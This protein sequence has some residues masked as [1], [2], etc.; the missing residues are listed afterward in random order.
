MT[1]DFVNPL[2]HEGDLTVERQLPG[3]I[4]VSAGWL[5]SRGLRLPV[6]I[7]TNLGPAIGTKSYAVLNSTGGL[8]STTT[9]P[10][11]PAGDRIDNKSGDI[12]TG[13]SIANSWY[14]GLVLTMRHPMSHGIEFLLNYTFSKSTDDGAVSGANGT[15][16]GTDW[17]LDP[18]NQRQE[19]SLSDLYQKHRFTGSVIY[20]PQYFHKLTNKAEKALLDGWAFSMVMTKYSGAPV[21]AQISGFPSG[22]VDYGVTGGEVTNTGGSTGGRPPQ[23][24]R[25]VILGHGLTDVDFRITRD[26]AVREKFHLQFLAEAFNIFNHTNITAV[27]GTAFNYSAVGS[28]TCPASVGAGT[29]GC[30]APNP[31][32]YAPTSSNS[33]NGLYGARQ[34]QLSA[35]FI[36]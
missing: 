16:N 13:Y 9:V 4:S 8:A 30:L 12:L 5:F 29:N 18:H 28:A 27:N 32:F 23:Y 7:D 19:N 21:F 17:P 33:P 20:A 35:K 25:N 11:Y 3:N 14:N 36:F 10:W 24:G 26:F 22:G 34:L 1:K 31:T 2:V 6:F 15:F